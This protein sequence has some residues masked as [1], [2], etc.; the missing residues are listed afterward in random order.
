MLGRL[1][2]SKEFLAENKIQPDPGDVVIIEE[3]KISVRDLNKND[4]SIRE[5]PKNTTG[6]VITEIFQDSPA[7]FLSIEDVIVEFQKK[8]VINANQFSRLVNEII[9]K[10]KKTLLFATFNR[11]NQRGYFTIKL[12]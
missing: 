5:L 10:G 3:L 11:K 8:K 1:E 7:G 12:E 9:N 4:I 6:V 2:S